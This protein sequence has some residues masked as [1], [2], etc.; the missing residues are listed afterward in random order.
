MAAA[1]G[2]AKALFAFPLG[3][4]WALSQ[5]FGGA[6]VPTAGPSPGGHSRPQPTTRLPLLGFSPL[7]NFARD[8]ERCVS[9]KLSLTVHF[10]Q[11]RKPASLPGLRGPPTLCRLAWCLAVSWP[12]AVSLSFLFVCVAVTTALF[13]LCSH[14]SVLAQS[15]DVL[16]GSCDTLWR[17]RGSQGAVCVQLKPH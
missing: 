7:R 5:S 6:W 14:S 11:I 4:R 12:S 8:D 1:D 9:S 2:R 3:L 13:S 10:I 15:G 17:A 16:S